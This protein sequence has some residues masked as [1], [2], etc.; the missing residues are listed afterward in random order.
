MIDR[1]RTAIA[2][3]EQ[4]PESEQEQLAALWEETLRDNARWRDRFQ[5]PRSQAFFAQLRA[6]A[7]L[8]DVLL[9]EKCV[10]AML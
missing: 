6:E 2:A 3:A 1:S 10:R 9:L 5:Q 4:L 8:R 7:Q